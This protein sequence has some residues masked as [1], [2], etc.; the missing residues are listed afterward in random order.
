MLRADDDAPLETGSDW[1]ASDP[2]SRACGWQMP[3]L[4]HATDAASWQPSAYRASKASSPVAMTGSLLAVVGLLSGFLWLNVTPPAAVRHDLVTIS[5]K[6]APPPPP[7]QPPAP[8]KHQSVT[9][10]NQPQVVT[11]PPVIAISAPSPL[12]TIRQADPPPIV[13]AASDAP[14]VVAA[15]P[16]PPPAVAS[17]GDLSSTMISATPPKYPLESRR[18]HEQG[19]V[20]LKLVLA[21]DGRVSD[22]SV[23]RSSGSD[24]LDRAALSA[25]RT[26]RWKPAMRDGQAV[27][28]QGMVTIPFVLQ[29]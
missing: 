12:A 26:W 5:L 28:V 11:P 29:R 9:Q 10:P 2:A 8:H 20:V 22:I 14:A 21:A 3:P 7:H 15:P 19:T 4:M 1:I 18:A 23:A 16:A 25:V 17:A 24:R 6:T 27:M 13:N